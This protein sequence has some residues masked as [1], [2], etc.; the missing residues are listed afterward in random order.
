[1]LAAGQQR[2]G[3]VSSGSLSGN[4]D[5]VEPATAQQYEI[6]VTVAEV[7][8]K[9]A[10]A[11][12]LGK[13]DQYP[14][15][16][17]AD[18]APVKDVQP[19]QMVAPPAIQAI[20]AT[21]IDAAPT[22]TGSP[23]IMV[24]RWMKDWAGKNLEAY[25]SHYDIGFRPGDGKEHAAWEAERRQ[26]IAEAASIKVRAKNMTVDQQSERVATVRFEETI[27]VG[28]SKKRS[29]KKLLL[30]RGVRDDEWKIWEEKKETVAEAKAY[31]VAKAKTAK[32]KAR[33][34]AKVKAEAA[35]AGKASL[36]VPL[37]Y[38]QS[39]SKGRLP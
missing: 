3:V 9:A 5:F 11:A 19:A 31:A 7:A 18:A 14:P 25:L 15:T 20:P 35:L 24:E 27:E 32:V 36:S 17:P 34:A 4:G 37:V 21:P 12:T 28:R 26:R 13:N 29:L 39:D 23:E 16:A 1:M 38:G 10:D 22:P 6:A 33:R 8:I 2:C 30:I